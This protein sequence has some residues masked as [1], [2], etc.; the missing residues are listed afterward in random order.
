V[1]GQLGEVLVVHPAKRADAK[2]RGR[3]LFIETNLG[4]KHLLEDI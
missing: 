2:I 1:T 4:D 3:S